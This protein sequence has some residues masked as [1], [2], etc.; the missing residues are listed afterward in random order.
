MLPVRAAVA[1]V[2]VAVLSQASPVSARPAVLQRA[3]LPLD[4]GVQWRASVDP[5]TGLSRVASGPGLRLIAHPTPTHAEFDAV[6]RQFLDRHR[7][8]FGASAAELVATGTQPVGSRHT[9]ATYRQVVGGLP[10]L[11]ARVQ[12]MFRGPVAVVVTSSA[13]DRLASG[14]FVLSAARAEMLASAELDTRQISSAR[15]IVRNERALLPTDQA[16]R[17]VWHL[18]IATDAPLGRHEVVIDAETGAVLRY[19]DLIPHGVVQV[20]GDVAPPEPGAPSVHR[21]LPGWSDADLDGRAV[22]DAGALQVSLDGPLVGITDP[23]QPLATASF[24]VDGAQSIEQLSW[25]Q[26]APREQLDAWFWAHRAI[27][28][29]RQLAPALPWLNRKLGVHINFDDGSADPYCNAFYMPLTY[30]EPTSEDIHFFRAGSTGSLDCIN[31][32]TIAAVV[33]HEWGH[34]F[35]DHL[36]PD[37]LAYEYIES[38]RSISEGVGDYVAASILDDP[39]VPIDAIVAPN[40][41]ATL[42]PRHADNSLR[43]PDDLQAGNVHWNGQIWAGTFWD[44]RG[45]LRSKYG[46]TPGTRMADQLHADVLRASPDWTT[47][48][49]L[50]IAID[51][52]DDDP[53]NGSP[54]SCEINLAFAQHGLLPESPA[55]NRDSLRVGHEAELAVDEPGDQDIVAQLWALPG[56][57]AVDPASPELHYRLGNGSIRQLAMNQDGDSFRAVIPAVA[58]GST[59]NYQIVARS[60]SGETFTWPQDGWY[61]RSIG[62]S[63]R[64][65]AWSFESGAEG[66]THGADDPTQDDWA[67]GRP[68]GMSGDP[69]TPASG[70]AIAGT[71]LGD[72]GNGVYSG[73]MTRSWLAS[74]AIDCGDCQDLGLRFRRWID[75]AAGD[76]VRVS[77]G[78]TVLWQL[79]GP[80]TDI[81]WTQDEV[82]LAPVAEALRSGASVEFELISDGSGEGG[83]WNL[84]DVE[85]V[86]SLTDPG[87]GGTDVVGG[88][89][90][91]GG[92]RGPTGLVFLLAALLVA[93]RR[94]S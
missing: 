4:H 60:H 59:L 18:T 9:A 52:D 16:L 82:D 37:G 14:S 15:S 94:R 58:D 86:F 84:D 81:A 39:V 32:A 78:G 49:D 89:A 50:A 55:P 72:V 75:L 48:Y 70:E 29:G 90:A 30:D 61:S 43:Y 44:L 53:T 5:H 66:W 79:D 62:Q 11:G 65:I 57:G 23:L 87:N 64:L 74:P 35:H 21:A 6:A 28:Y 40:S 85:I 2:S 83:G 19:A 88:C 26:T 92:S 41:S 80:V 76:Q 22:V 3:Q 42:P 54:N 24:T 68:A 34:G 31:T 1:L 12:V 91:A 69:S 63:D 51:D 56:C 8:R 77:V 93:R 7:A 25:P 20:T 67:I 36:L 45:L 73:N 17:S 71:D 13:D 33:L 47:M 38:Q 46:A 27:E 10:V